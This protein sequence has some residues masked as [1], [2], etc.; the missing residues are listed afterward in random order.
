MPRFCEG[1]PAGEYIECG[2]AGK[3]QALAAHV[4]AGLSATLGRAVRGTR[5]GLNDER[6]EEIRQEEM[7]QRW[8]ESDEAEL[9]EDHP[10]LASVVHECERMARVTGQCTLRS[11]GLD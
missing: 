5:D 2:F 11:I 4:A 6:I 3:D 10:G 9:L 8:G 1:C 7:E